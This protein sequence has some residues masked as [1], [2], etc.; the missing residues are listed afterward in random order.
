[1]GIPVSPWVSPITQRGS[2]IK[3]PRVFKR[4]RGRIIMYKRS[5][6]NQ[7]IKPYFSCYTPLGYPMFFPNGEPGWHYEIPR[8]EVFD[9]ETINEEES[10]EEDEESILLL[11]VP[12]STS[13]KRASVRW[14]IIPTVRNRYLLK[15]T[16]EDKNDFIPRIRQ[17]VLVLANFHRRPT[18]HVAAIFVGDGFDSSGLKSI[19]NYCPVKPHKIGPDFL[20]RVFRVKL[21]DLKDQLFEKHVLGI[22]EAYVYVVT[23]QKRGL[24]HAF[25]SLNMTYRHKMTNPDHYDLIICIEIRTNHLE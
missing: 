11:K 3:S 21:K 4:G 1:M 20:V 7:T 12:Y 8:H 15:K 17:W 25:S 19:V 6:N 13:S 23:F 22:V 9:N 14:E 18:T 2:P 16:N 24:P 5:D 10:V